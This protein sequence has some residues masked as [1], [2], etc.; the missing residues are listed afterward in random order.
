MVQ[1]E[2]DGR[3]T[4][5]IEAPAAETVELLGAFRGWHPERIPMSRDSDGRWTITLDAPPGDY[6]FRYV[7]DG[8]H[9]V[10]D[11][12][13]HGTRFDA[14]GRPWSR[15]WRPNWAWYEAGVLAAIPPCTAAAAGEGEASGSPTTSP[16]TPHSQPRAA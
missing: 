5:E 11:E 12:H 13:A 14:G 3:L 15:A 2:S 6:L 10:I 4:F 16:T 1:L 7:V 9:E 8:E